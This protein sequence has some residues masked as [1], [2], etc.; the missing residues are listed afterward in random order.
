M[1]QALAEIITH[2]RSIPS[3][4]DFYRAVEAYQNESWATSKNLDALRTAYLGIARNAKKI[5][6]I[7]NQVEGFD[8]S[9]FINNALQQSAQ[10]KLQVSESAGNLLTGI[11]L[12][13][14]ERDAMNK[15]VP[16]DATDA[17]HI[18]LNHVREKLS[19]Q[20]N[21]TLGDEIHIVRETAKRLL[22]DTNHGQ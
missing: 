7:I 4:R 19:E 11:V 5:L 17:V 16:K 6:E 22:K 15:H 10:S 18:A 14:I 13:L 9:A 21:C 2:L 20:L 12:L 8:V 3:A 1:S